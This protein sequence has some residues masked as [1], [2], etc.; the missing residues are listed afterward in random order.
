MTGY[1]VSY[2]ALVCLVWLV[3]QGLDAVAK[4]V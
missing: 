3:K 2:T 1:I 4:E